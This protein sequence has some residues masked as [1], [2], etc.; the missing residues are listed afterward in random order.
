MISKRPSS[1]PLAAPKRAQPPQQPRQQRSLFARL[2]VPLMIICALSFSIRAGEVLIG[3]KNYAG[4]AM[5]QQASE[6]EPPAM[7]DEDAPAPAPALTIKDDT[8][9]KEP[10]VTP[11]EV[12]IPA[13][14]PDASDTTLD[15][16]EIPLELFEDLEARKAALEKREQELSMREAL[17]KAGEQELEQKYEELQALRETIEGL[18][19]TQSEEEEARIA[20]LVKIY[21]GMKAK[22]AAAIFNTLDI[23][24]LLQVMGRMSERKS[25]PILAEMNPDRA[26][27][28]TIRLAHEKKMPDVLGG[29][30]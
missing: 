7:P 2:L 14:W 30:E 5:A 24:I 26:R 28:V 22:D 10:D 12:V 25:G 23:G 3:V 19:G 6:E 18:L 29:G 1:Q 27:I 9:P 21:E 16:S 15:Y 20:S 11:E 4:T 17:L 8:P 13:P